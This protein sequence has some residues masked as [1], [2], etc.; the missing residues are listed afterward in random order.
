VLPEGAQGN[1]IEATV[2]DGVLSVVIPKAEAPAPR[3][4]AVKT[5]DLIDKAKQLFTKKD[6]APKATEASP[7]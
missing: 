5:G 4:I 2:K 6:E 1:A 3:R 7:S